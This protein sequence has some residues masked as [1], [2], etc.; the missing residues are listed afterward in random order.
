MPMKK[1]KLKSKA[2]PNRA[3]L[4]SFNFPRFFLLLQ[5]G[6]YLRLQDGGR[7]KLKRP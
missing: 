3:R 4:K 6:G 7:L 2:V 1:F 5:S